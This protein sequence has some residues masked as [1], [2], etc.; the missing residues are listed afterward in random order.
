MT[1]VAE[2]W[3]AMASSLEATFL[4]LCLRTRWE[5]AALEAAQA[6]AAQPNLPWDRVR[7]ITQMENLAPLLYI[8]L[9]QRQ[10]APPAVEEDL[11]RAYRDT[12]WRNT[13]LFQQLEDLLHALAARSVR[14]ILLKG[15]GLSKT[16]YG[17]AGVRPLGDL[18]LLVRREDVPVALAALGQLGYRPVSCE[19][20]AG[21]DLT[22]ENEV[23]LSKEGAFQTPVELHWSL[24][25]SPHHQQR[26]QMDRFW[27]TALP[28]AVG[29][30]R[31]WVLA[32]EA[33]LLHLCGHLYLHHAGLGLLWR[34]DVAEVIGFYSDRIDWQ[35]LLLQAQVCD[36]VLPLQN[37]LTE[38][39]ADWG[40][41]IP[42]G[43]LARLQAL[44]VSPKEAEV[45]GRLTSPQRPVAQR[46][47]ADLANMPGWPAR[48]RYAWI[49]LFPSAAYMR[50][51]YGLRHR[52]LLPLYYPYRWAIGLRSAIAWD[53]RADRQSTP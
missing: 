41:N 16:V 49:N 31:T 33:Q 21:A 46:F 53:R 24:F 51:R 18:D 23:M 14:V 5:R 44:P 48:L 6:L 3:E 29:D 26:L 39:A 43:V 9:R 47:W 10:W 30:A 28:T 36:L 22:F 8:I 12:V 52:I 11:R 40:V 4:R 19:T 38:L 35:E 45:F 20:H 34:H 7:R 42:S 15:A 37:V 1:S 32:P 50:R 25:D 13:F 2:Q 27:E 17:R